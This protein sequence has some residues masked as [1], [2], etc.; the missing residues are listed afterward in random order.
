[1]TTSLDQARQRIGMISCGDTWVWGTAQSGDVT[2]LIHVGSLKDGTRGM[3]YV[4]RWLLFPDS[5]YTG[6]NRE[7]KIETD[8]P[9]TGRLTWTT[10]I[11][12]AV[13]SATSFEIHRYRPTM[14]EKCINIVLERMIF[15]ER[16]T[17]NPTTN[18]RQQA[19]NTITGGTWFTAE[20]QFVGLNVREGSTSG[21][22][23][24]RAIPSA[25][26]TRDQDTWTLQL[27]GEVFASTDTLEFVA[28]RDY[29]SAGTPDSGF[30]T[31][32]LGSTTT[33]APLEWL[34]WEA[35]YEVLR[36]VWRSVTGADRAAILQEAQD[37]WAEVRR[38]RA[39]YEPKLSRPLF[40]NK[41]EVRWGGRGRDW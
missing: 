2:Y 20:Q 32:T 6:T 40:R 7:R 30:N 31:L 23:T 39:F 15:L 26:I 24:Y 17:F 34:A 10:T 1:M 29:A 19:V 14:I 38:Q 28:T 35:Y 22:Y 33:T 8:D 12:T 9:L 41:Q 4:D 36:N 11:G 16:V 5:V 3:I 25:Y 18:A 13:D 37:A 21:E 27:P